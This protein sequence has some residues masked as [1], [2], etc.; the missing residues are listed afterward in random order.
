MVLVYTTAINLIN[1]YMPCSGSPHAAL[2]FSSIY[3]NAQYHRP[4]TAAIKMKASLPVIALQ[5]LW[6]NLQESDFSSTIHLIPFMSQSFS[7]LNLVIAIDTLLIS[8][9]IQSWARQISQQYAPVCLRFPVE[10]YILSFVNFFFTNYPTYYRNAAVCILFPFI[11]LKKPSYDRKN[12]IFYTGMQLCRHTTLF[13]LMLNI[14][15]HLLKILRE[16]K[17][18][19]V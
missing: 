8:L 5:T 19:K 6:H 3:Q 10:C 9:R 12:S 1:Y 7:Q 11:T 17:G 15:F 4:L 18:E 16:K 14:I 2:H 13:R